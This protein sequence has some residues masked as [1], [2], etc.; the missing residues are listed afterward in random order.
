MKDTKMRKMRAMGGNLRCE[1]DRHAG[2][3]EIDGSDS[4]SDENQE[5]VNDLIE[6]EDESLGR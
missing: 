5:K 2:K 1:R 3:E 4:D 6:E